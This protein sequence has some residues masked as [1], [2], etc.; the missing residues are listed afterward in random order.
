MSSRA[1]FRNP[2]PGPATVC[3][4]LASVPQANALAL[5]LVA[6]SSPVFRIRAGQLPTTITRLWHKNAL[7]VASDR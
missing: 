7:T 1:R 4:I 5:C 2:P 3:Y 6:D